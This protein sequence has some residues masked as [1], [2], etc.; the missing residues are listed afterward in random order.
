MKEGIIIGYS[1]HAYV[2]IEILLANNYSIK[3]YC[4][5][6]EKEFNPYGLSYLGNENETEVREYFID[7]FVFIGIGDNTLREKIFRKLS[8]ER[9]TMPEVRHPSAVISRSAQLG[10]ATLVMPGVIINPFTTIGSC[11]ICNTSSVIEHEVKIGD[12]SHIAPGAVIAGGVE[13][14]KNCFIGANSIIK[15]GLKIGNNVIIGAGSV[16]LNDI[17][18][19]SMVFGNPAKKVYRE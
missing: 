13:I 2:V 6:K 8:N 9:T 19:S 1:G 5:T 3:S 4:E 11:V 14:G 12:F 15:Q 16:V 7:K 10:A 17:P 18:G